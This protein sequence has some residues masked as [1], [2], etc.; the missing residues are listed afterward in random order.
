[1]RPKSQQFK[2]RAWKNPK[3]AEKHSG[4]HLGYSPC[5][6]PKRCVLVWAKFGGA[7]VAVLGCYLDYTFST[8]K[9]AL[10]TSQRTTK[11]TINKIAAQAG[12]IV[13]RDIEDT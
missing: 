6:Y 1:M 9:Q 10:N 3:E 5:E 12:L 7:T 8:S 2:S 11:E 4:E 13:S